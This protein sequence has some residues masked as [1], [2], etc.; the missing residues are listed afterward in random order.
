MKMCCL[1]GKNSV[2]KGLTDFLNMVQSVQI[3][4]ECKCINTL[5]L[6]LREVRNVFTKPTSK[7]YVPQSLG[8]IELNCN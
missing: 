4:C 1:G 7:N 3:V 6:W 8:N 2:V 5:C